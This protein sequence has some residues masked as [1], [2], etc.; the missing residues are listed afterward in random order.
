MPP[1][2]GKASIVEGEDKIVDYFDSVSDALDDNVFEP[3]YRSQS[4]SSKDLKLTETFKNLKSFRHVND[5]LKTVKVI[6]FSLCVI[7]AINSIGQIRSHPLKAVV[8]GLVSV[9]LFRVASN[10]YI[11]NYAAI[12]AKKL[13]GDLQTLGTTLFQV[14]ASALGLSGE[15]PIQQMKKGVMWDCLF[16]GTFTSIAI[17]KV[18]YCIYLLFYLFVNVFLC[19]SSAERNICQVKT[20]NNINWSRH[21]NE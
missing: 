17:D 9:D 11:K 7:F 19:F 18:I 2:P 1:K 15:D 6:T 21:A 13:G 3:M 8:F 5:K 4:D 10:C 16:Q 14:A 20:F 12:A